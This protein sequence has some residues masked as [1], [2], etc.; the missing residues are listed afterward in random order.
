MVEAFNVLRSRTWSQHENTDELVKYPLPKS[1]KSISKRKTSVSPIGWASAQKT[2]LDPPSL[3]GFAPEEW[4]TWA[5]AIG[6]NYKTIQRKSSATKASPRWT[7]LAFM[8]AWSSRS[9][10]ISSS[11]GLSIHGVTFL[12]KTE[13]SST[14]LSK[15]KLT[16]YDIRMPSTFAASVQIIST[17]KSST[18]WA[19]IFASLCNSATC[20]L[21]ESCST[22]KRCGKSSSFSLYLKKLKSFGIWVLCGRHHKWGRF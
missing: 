11:P 13:E 7:G 20:Q 10:P 17:L 19:T 22:L 6:A 1:S 12:K 2:T 9:P 16:W 5:S 8:N 3:P 4:D 21:I 15:M 14:S 18:V